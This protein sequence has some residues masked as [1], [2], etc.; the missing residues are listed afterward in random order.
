MNIINI[1]AKKTQIIETI[2]TSKLL[3][4]F[5]L[6]LVNRKFRFKSKNSLGINIPKKMNG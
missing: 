2:K 3:S 1:I 6:S 5:I 4:I